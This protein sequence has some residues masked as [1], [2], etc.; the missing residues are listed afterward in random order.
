MVARYIWDVEAAGPNP[1]A[2]TRRNLTFF[3]NFDIIFIEKAQTATH[4]EASVL[5][6]EKATYVPCNISQ[7]WC[8][9][10]MLGSYPGDDVRLVRL[11]PKVI[12]LL[13]LYTN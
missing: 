4:L 9:G 11:R 1:V 7:W 5:G 2:P 6:I 13:D 3:E 12:C 10:S 8:N